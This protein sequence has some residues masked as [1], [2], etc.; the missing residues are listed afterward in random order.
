MGF[1]PKEVGTERYKREVPVPV[2]VSYPNSGLPKISANIIINL[3][4]SWT[5]SGSGLWK[6]QIQNLL[7]IN[8]VPTFCSKKFSLK[9]AYTVKLVF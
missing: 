8:F 4:N 6:N 7:Y 9:L 1:Y 5:G 3:N 2:V